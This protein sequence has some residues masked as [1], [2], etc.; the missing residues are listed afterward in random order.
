MMIIKMPVDRDTLSTAFLLRLKK[1]TL[2][3]TAKPFTKPFKR[4]LNLM[5]LKQAAL[6]VAFRDFFTA[7]DTV[8]D[9]IFTNRPALEVLQK[10]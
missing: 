3:S 1:F 9:L 4:T 10:P 6:T 8:S 7:Q 2:G 5:G